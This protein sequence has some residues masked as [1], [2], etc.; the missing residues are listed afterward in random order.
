MS[1]GTF[2]KGMTLGVTVGA[3][4]YAVTSTSS[5]QKRRMKR[6]ANKAIK[7]VGSVIDGITCM[8]K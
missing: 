8:M 5:K 4:T 6:T 7:T 1:M 2:I 3:L